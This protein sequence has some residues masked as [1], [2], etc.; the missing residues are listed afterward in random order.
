MAD[1]ERK[2]GVGANPQDQ[3]GKDVATLGGPTSHE[4]GTEYQF[5]TPQAQEAAEGAGEIAQ[6]GSSAGPDHKRDDGREP[7]AYAERQSA[8][9]TG[10]DAVNKQPE[11]LNE[12]GRQRVQQPQAEQHGE[13]GSGS[14]S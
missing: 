1:N 9:S 8:G 4:M 5:L 3:S 10:G 7:E 11:S 14:A 12:I 13:S 2:D 6:P